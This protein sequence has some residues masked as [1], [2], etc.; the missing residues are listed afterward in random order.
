[1][2]SLR[3]MDSE[4]TFQYH[5]IMKS[6]MAYMRK[7]YF[8]CSVPHSGELAIGHQLIGAREYRYNLLLDTSE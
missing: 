8:K 2:G 4:L 6:K 1:M 3:R 7:F 5:D